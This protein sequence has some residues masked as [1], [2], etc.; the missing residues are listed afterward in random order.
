MII[1]VWMEIKVILAGKVTIGSEFSF[2]RFFYRA[3]SSELRLLSCYSVG[4]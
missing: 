3:V 2:G 1:R 4:L